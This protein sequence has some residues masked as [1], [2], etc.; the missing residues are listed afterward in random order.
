M[1]PTLEFAHVAIME[2]N[3][4]NFFIILLLL[5]FNYIISVAS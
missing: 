3:I 4:V 5:K 1:D 2:L